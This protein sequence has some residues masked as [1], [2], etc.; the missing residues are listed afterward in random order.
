MSGAVVF[1][2]KQLAEEK[3]KLESSLTARQCAAV[4]ALEDLKANLDKKYANLRDA[5]REAHRK[6]IEGLNKKVC[7]QHDQLKAKQ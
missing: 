7:E 2:S 3:S 5:A 6:E 1:R 4:R